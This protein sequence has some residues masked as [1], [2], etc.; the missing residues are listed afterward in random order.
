MARDGPEDPRT[1]ALEWLKP[2]VER[3]YHD[4]AVVTADPPE[5]YPPGWVLNKSE[6]EYDVLH[7]L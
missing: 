4:D 3:S 6:D 7:R 2:H 1:R 5:G